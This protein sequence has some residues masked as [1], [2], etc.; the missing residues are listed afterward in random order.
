[1]CNNFYI[2]FDKLKTFKENEN[3]QTYLFHYF[4]NY[5]TSVG[6]K[7]AAGLCV[8]A[9]GFNSERYSLMDINYIRQFELFFDKDNPNKLEKYLIKKAPDNLENILSEM[10]GTYYMQNNQLKKAYKEFKKLPNS[11]KAKYFNAETKV[12]YGYKN[13]GFA[14]FDAAIFSGAV[15]HYF[16]TSYLSRCDNTHLQF[17][18]LKDEDIVRNKTDLVKMMIFIE[19]RASKKDANTGYYYYMLGNVWYNLGPEGWYERILQF[20]YDVDKSKSSKFFNYMAEFN[21]Q[22]PLKYYQ[23]A[24]K[25]TSDKELEAKIHFMMAKTVQYAE[26]YPALYYDSFLLLKN[27]YSNTEYFKDVIEECSYFD[28]YVNPQN[29]RD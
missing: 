5:Y 25:N 8:D 17:N 1:M 27:E 4:S 13:D 26:H 21:I 7:V 15:R 20:R 16:S 24:L 3:I 12:N 22:I 19:N 29:Y 6:D 28:K 9:Y 10:R 23:L 11:F 14:L 2:E 18:F